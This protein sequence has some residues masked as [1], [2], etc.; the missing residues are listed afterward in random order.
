MANEVDDFDDFI[1]ESFDGENSELEERRKNKRFDEQLPA[2][3][4][5]EE[6]IALNI[7]EKGVLLRTSKPARFFPLDKTID[8]ELKLQEQWIQ[9]KGKVVWIQSDSVHS[10]V[11]LLIQDAQEPYFQF[12]RQFEK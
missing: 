3:I 10:K 12:F 6:C 8:F 7:S 9:I 5:E 4:K 11:G 2:R 1:N